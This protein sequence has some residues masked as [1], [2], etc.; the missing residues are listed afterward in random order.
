ML[1]STFR[2]SS[3]MIIKSLQCIPPAADLQHRVHDKLT[4]TVVLNLLDVK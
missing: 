3:I 2:N 1:R 4:L